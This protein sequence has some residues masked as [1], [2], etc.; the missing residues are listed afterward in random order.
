MTSYSDRFSSQEEYRHEVQELAKFINN[1]HLCN[2]ASEAELLLA[3]EHIKE[4]EVDS[5]QASIRSELFRR[6]F[7]ASVHIPK[8]PILGQYYDAK[9][10]SQI[11]QYERCL[12]PVSLEMKYTLPVDNYY[13]NVVV[14]NSGIAA[15]H[16]V[17]EVLSL[18]SGEKRY[19]L[20]HRVSYYET[21][22]LFNFFSHSFVD[23]ELCPDVMFF[24][25]VEYNGDNTENELETICDKI[26]NSDNTTYVIVDVTLTPCFDVSEMTKL[27]KKDSIVLFFVESNLKIGQEG[28]ELANCGILRFYSQNEIVVQRLKS[29]LVNQRTI[30][31]TTIP[32]PSALMLYSTKFDTKKYAQAICKKTELLT[33]LIPSEYRVYSSKYYRCPI[34]FLEHDDWTKQE[35]DE[36]KKEILDALSRNNLPGYEGSS[37]GL[38]KMR[39]EIINMYGVDRYRIKVSSGVYFSEGI[40]VFLDTLAKLG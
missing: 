14:Y 12:E 25:L 35:Y 37:F 7:E 18:L 40:E 38:R 4:D 32:Y 27:I 21:L 39:F 11:F 10:I 3:S 30:S 23:D 34:F 17:L 9:C 16:G 8:S 22:L 13:T 6:V 1:N 33:E 29:F 26:N 36:L 19:H 15:I 24:E 31:G 28:L 2:S 20:Y 5:L